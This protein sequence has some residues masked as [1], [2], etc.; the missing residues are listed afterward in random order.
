MEWKA[1]I[2]SSQLDEI[3]QES[4]SQPVMIFKHST[5]CSISTMAM[6]RLERGTLSDN[7]SVYY[8][9]LLTYRPISSEIAERFSVH[10]ESPQVLLIRNGECVYVESHNGID[11]DEINAQAEA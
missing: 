1:L 7:L 9:D 3:I 2:Q 10:H 8:L 4:L 6:G 11:V 5:R